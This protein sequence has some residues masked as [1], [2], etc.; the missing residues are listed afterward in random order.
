MVPCQS[1]SVFLRSNFCMENTV[2][3]PSFGDPCECIW[4]RHINLNHQRGLK[5]RS[6]IMR[7][8]DMRAGPFATSSQGY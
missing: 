8:I 7:A 2:F 3:F 4:L 6:G 5:R 1:Y